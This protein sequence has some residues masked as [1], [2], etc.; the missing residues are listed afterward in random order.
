MSSEASRTMFA[1]QAP[2]LLTAQA[3]RPQ[4][5]KAVDGAQARCAVCA[6]PPCGTAGWLVSSWRED[7]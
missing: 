5:L 6:R 7:C 3:D 2:R 1:N 4:S